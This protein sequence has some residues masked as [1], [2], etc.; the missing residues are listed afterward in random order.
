MADEGKVEFELVS[1]E[2]LLVSEPVDMIVVPGAEGDFGV[3]PRHAPMISSLRTG[4]I[5]IYEGQT[6]RE[7][8][9]VAGGFCEVTGE[10]CTIL[11][12]DAIPVKD[13]DVAR[14]DAEL[15]NLREDAADAKDAAERAAA[16]A[17]IAVREAMKA[18]AA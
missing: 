11:A 3:L 15:K 18:V 17:K 2:R 12:E 7:S 1:P 8:I 9:F 16:E 13:I 5:R 6:V 4:V 10:R 14:I